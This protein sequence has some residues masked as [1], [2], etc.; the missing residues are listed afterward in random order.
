MSK[1]ECKSS[2]RLFDKSYRHCGNN[3]ALCT[4]FMTRTPYH[5]KTS[6]IFVYAALN[7]FFRSKKSRYCRAVAILYYLKHIKISRKI[8]SFFHNLYSFSKLVIQQR[9]PSLLFIP[10]FRSPFV[11]ATTKERDKERLSGGQRNL[12]FKRILI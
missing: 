9:G 6:S 1:E 5:P 2:S 3:D 10:C 11:G 8:H 4:L 12:I 7:H